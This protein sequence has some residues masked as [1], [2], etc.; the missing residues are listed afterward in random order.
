MKKGRKR[1]RGPAAV[2][3]HAKI[4][5]FFPVCRSRKP[6]CRILAFGAQPAGSRPVTERNPEPVDWPSRT[7]RSTCRRVHKRSPG[8]T[9]RPSRQPRCRTS[10]R[11]VRRKRLT[12]GSERRIRRRTPLTKHKHASLLEDADHNNGR[13]H[14]DPVP[15]FARH[16]RDD[17]R[18]DESRDLDTRT[19]HGETP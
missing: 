18:H 12:F 10:D 14:R 13:N 9:E 7:R 2:R 6:A 16:E 19:F 3:A 8:Q 1:E 17:E 11:G 4:P 5:P 15:P